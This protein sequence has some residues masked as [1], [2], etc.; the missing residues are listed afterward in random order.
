MLVS[1]SGCTAR[2]RFHV[3]S[4]RFSQEERGAESAESYQPAVSGC[5]GQWENRVTHIPR[6]RE[7]VRACGELGQIKELR[8]LR[9]TVLSC[10]YYVNGFATQ[11]TQHDDTDLLQSQL[12]HLGFMS[13]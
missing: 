5:R 3:N 9:T 1:Q 2:N 13:C 7:W 6:L 4:P 11:T 10:V 8:D 12:I